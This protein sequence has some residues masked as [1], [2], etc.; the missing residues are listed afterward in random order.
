MQ[1]EDRPHSAAPHR[2][3]ISSL[4]P[5][6]ESYPGHQRNRRGEWLTHQAFARRPEPRQGHGNVPQD[7]HLGRVA[8]LLATSRSQP[9]SP[10]RHDEQLDRPVGA[11]QAH[12]VVDPVSVTRNRIFARD[13]ADEPSLS[14]R[15]AQ[16]SARGVA[17]LCAPCEPAHV[18]LQKASR[19]RARPRSRSNPFG[20]RGKES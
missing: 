14:L 3:L 13:C 12:A 17:R 20:G 19:C 4:P 15:N 9:S 7:F 18:A 16:Y 11:E 10:D 5:V 2:L 1:Q 8:F 6:P